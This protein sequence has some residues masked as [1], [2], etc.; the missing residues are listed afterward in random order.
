MERK[1]H[2]RKSLGWLGDRWL[3]V[4]VASVVV[5]TVAA[6]LIVMNFVPK[7]NAGVPAPGFELRDQQGRLTSLKQFRG[8]VVVLTFIDPECTQICPLTTQSMLRALKILGPAA[9]SQVQLLGVDAN[10]L[11]TK[12]ADVADY[13]RVHDMQGR[14]RFLT[15]SRAQLDQVWRNYHVYVAAVNNDIEH[16][17]VVFLIDKKGTEHQVYSTPM[18]YEAVGDQARTLA[19]GIAALLP[20]HPAVPAQVPPA[21]ELATFKPSDTMKLAVVGPGQQS[22]IVGGA[23]PHLLVFFAG[24]LRENSNVQARL[25][26]LD[27]YAEMARREDWP[28][29]IA[30]DEVPTE[31]SPTEARQVLVSLAGTLHTP[32]VEDQS[33]RLADGYGVDDLPWFVLSSSSGKIL[34]HH[35]GWLSDTALNQQVRLSM[36]AAQPVADP[37]TR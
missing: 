31:P 14:W 19:E 6:V 12:V 36:A 27:R 8:K 5:A 33:G 13:T 30:V 2:S 25:A 26:A 15:G 28:S 10:P 34:W 35:D 4:F 29:P 37:P 17:A 18:S 7:Q 3:I 24:W 9:A 16:E 20:S 21:N 1:S 11:K 23:H 22:V 32:I